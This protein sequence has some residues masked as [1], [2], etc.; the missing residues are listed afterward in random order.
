MT[1]KNTGVTNK[2]GALREAQEEIQQ[3]RQ[4]LA[5]R[6]EQERQRNGVINQQRVLIQQYGIVT[7]MSVPDMQVS[8]CYIPPLSSHAFVSN[9]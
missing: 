9:S 8:A 4:Q 1:D 3:L 2:R 5:E 7:R 6:E